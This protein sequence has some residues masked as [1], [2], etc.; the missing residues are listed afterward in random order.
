MRWWG[1]IGE[2]DLLA[3][4]DF[5]QFASD[6]DYRLPAPPPSPLLRVEPHANAL[7]LYWDDS[8]ESVSDPTSELPG[9]LDFEGYRVYVGSDRQNP[10]QVAQF[11]LVD[12]VGF[13]TGLDA[14]R[15]TTP[16]VVDGVTYRYRH[17]VTNLRDGFKYY[18]AVTSYDVGDP[19]VGSLESGISQNKF[20]AVPGPSPGERSAGVTVFPNPYRV[21]A[22]WDQGEQVRDHYLWF[23]NLPARAVI[24]IYTLSGDLVFENRFDGASYQGL[25]ARGLYDPRQDLDTDAPAL[26]GAS[27]AWNLITAQG[28]AIA[29]GLYLWAVEDLDGG[30][31]ERG[32]FLVVKSDRE[33]F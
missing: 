8:P 30:R 29:S 12:S 15:L 11:D 4:A 18:G 5:A 13:N 1:G 16:H 19:R 28:Q 27:F 22:R 25:G 31:V 6:I 14:I 32:K 17:R 10:T 20:V 23:A 33:G 7:D 9:G 24:R 3:N 2:T 21:E 26:S